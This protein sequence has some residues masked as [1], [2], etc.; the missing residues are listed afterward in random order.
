VF[1][2][3][4]SGTRAVRRRAPKRGNVFYPGLLVTIALRRLR[5]VFS[6][7]HTLCVGTSFLAL[8]APCRRAAQEPFGAERPNE[9]SIAREP[10]LLV[11]YTLRRLRLF[12]SG[13]VF[14]GAPRPLPQSGTR[15]VRRRAPKRGEYCPGTLFTGS[16]RSAPLAP[17][18]RVVTSFLA[19]RAPYRRA[20]Q[21]PFGAERPNEE[22]IAREPSLLV[23]YALRR[24]RPVSGLNPGSIRSALEP[25]SWRSAPRGAERPKEGLKQIVSMLPIQQ[26]NVI[27]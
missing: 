16:M 14:L 9:E 6:W 2:P 22:S 11:P 23:P 4:Q 24:L 8:R 13:N 1:H 25:P 15:A 3:P 10:S 7:F 27:D 12:Q 26:C 19:L 21:E 17:C 20:A 18:F 5:P